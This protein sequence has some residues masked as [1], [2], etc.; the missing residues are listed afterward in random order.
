MSVKT[1]VKTNF[2]DLPLLKLAAEKLGG[3]CRIFDR[4]TEVK[5]WTRKE[6][7]VA[8]IMLPGWRYPLA[9]TA[10]NELVYDNHNGS[11]GARKTLDELTRGYE[12]EVT[13]AWAA[14]NGYRVQ[15]R[16]QQNNEVILELVQ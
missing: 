9:L 11:W 13:K 2:R 7:G 3:S 16:I 14:Q 6:M 15:T 10:K 1:T 4:M 8:E 12:E 5:I